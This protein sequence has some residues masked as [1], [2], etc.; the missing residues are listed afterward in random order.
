MVMFDQKPSPSQ[1]HPK[2]SFSWPCPL[3]RLRNTFQRY[4][5]VVDCCNGLLLFFCPYEATRLDIYSY[6]VYNPFTNQWMTTACIANK[7]PA[8]A[9]ADKSIAH[10]YAAL[11]YNPSESSF[12]RIIL[13][14]GFRYLDVYYYLLI[15][16]AGRS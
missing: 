7:P 1:D 15:F 13:F 12:H 16:G 3:R 11:A 6:H 4:C 14:K 9:P 2:A 8:A 5:I 10:M